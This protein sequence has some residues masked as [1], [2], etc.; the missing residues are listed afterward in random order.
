MHVYFSGCSSL[1]PNRSRYA[2]SKFCPV[3]DRLIRKVRHAGSVSAVSAV[4]RC[5]SS[6]ARVL[7]VLS[8]TLTVLGVPDVQGDTFTWKSNAGNRLDTP[9][10]WTN[11]AFPTGK[12]TAIT[13]DDD[14]ILT[15]STTAANP[16]RL[17]AALSARSL[18][19]NSTNTNSI[20]GRGNPYVLTLGEGG[21]TVNSPVIGRSGLFLGTGFGGQ[22][23][24]INIVM[25]AS[26]TW[27]NA[28]QLRVVDSITNNGHTLT[29]D[30]AGTT[31]LGGAAAAA[32]SGTGGL[33]KDGTGTL[34]LAGTNTFTGD[35]KVNAGTLLLSN[36]LALQNSGLNTD[37]AGSVSVV[38]TTLSLGGLL[39]SGNLAT[40][41]TSGYSG[42]TALTLNLA[43]TN[44]D[45][46]NGIVAN[47]A[48]NMTV[49][50]AGTGTQ[51]F[52]GANT[53]SGATT[54]SAGALRAA[55]N[56]ALGTN[57]AGT[58]V[59]SGAALELDGGIT[60]GA[61]SLGLS[62]TGISSNGALRN[63]S[64]SNTY[65]GA[66]TLN[67]AS[68]INADAGTLTI[69]SPTNITGAF[70]L[71]FGGSG[72]VVVND[73]IAT[74]AG[75][76]GKD[77]T[78]TVT[79]GATNS[80][81]G[82]TTINAGTLAYGTDNAIGT[83]GITISNSAALLNEGVATLDIGSFSDSVGAVTLIN[84]NIVGTT[85]VLTSTVTYVMQSG[86]VSANLAGNV[87]LSK[88]TTGTVVLSGSN[89]YTG[90]TTNSIAGSVLR[91][92]NSSAL[93]VTNGRTIVVSGAALEL[94]GGIEIGAEGL[95]LDGTGVSAGGALR[96]ISGNNIYGGTILINSLTRINS[97]A[98]TLTLDVATGDAITGSNDA[99]QFGGTGDIVIND[100]IA[101]GSGAVTKDG[102]GR[103]TLAGSNSFTSL[104]TISNGAVRVADNFG[105]GAINSGVTVISGA[106]LELSNNVVIGAEALTLNADGI[107]GTGALRNVQ[108]TNT[109]GGVIS[110]ATAA[111]IEADA[112]TQLN[113]T[114]T[115]GGNG[116]KTFD[117]PGNIFATNVISGTGTVTKTGVG[118][119]TL[120]SAANSFTNTL[121]V[122]NGTLSIA[123]INNA[124][125]TGTLGNSANAVTLGGSGTTG[126][127]LYTGNTAAS[128]KAFSLATG[129]AGAV[130]VDDNSAALTLSGAISGEGA[131]A[132][133]GA[134]ALVL[135][136]TNNYGGGT[137]VSAGTLAG[138]SASLQGNIT[139]NA[140]L[141]FDQSAN[142]TYAG[143]ASGSG[144][145]TKTGAGTLT[146]SGNNTY[147]GATT[148]AGGALSVSADNN[149][150]AATGAATAGQITLSNGGTLAVTAGFTLSANRGI[151][152]ETGGG[153]I[154]VA[155]GQNLSYAG[156]MAGS[157]AFNK[158]GAGTLTLSSSNSYTGMNT[159]SAGTVRAENSR[160]LGSL[161]AG[162]AITLAGGNLQLAADT[163][164]IFG[165]NTGYGTII[166]SNTTITSD[167]LTAGAGVTQQLGTLTMGAQTFS[168]ER[169]ANV[170]SGIATLAIGGATTL[171]GNA[172]FATAADT[173]LRF[174]NTLSGAVN[175]TKTGEGILTLNRGGGQ[176]DNTIT[177]GQLNIN[178]F[179]AL[180]TLPGTLTLSGG[181]TL[182]NTATNSVTVGNAKSISLGSTLTFLGSTNLNLGSGVTTL[183]NNTAIDVVANTLTL[184]G[185]VVGGAFGLTKNGAGTL[186]LLG[187]T[188]TNSFTGNSFIN[189]GEL[190]LNGTSRFGGTS[191]TVVTVETNA[192]LRVGASAGLGNVTLVLNNPEGLIL[193]GVITNDVTISNSGTIS[194]NY[195]N[196]DGTITIGEGVTVSSAANNFGTIPSTNTPGRIVMDND[197]TLAATATF[198]IDE[199]QGILLQPGVATFS[200]GTNVQVFIASSITGDGELRKTGAGNIR[201]TGS[202]SYTGGTVIDQGIIGITSD[203][204]LGAVSGQVKLN[205]GTLVAAQNNT[206]G[207]TNS[208]TTVNIDRTIVLGNGTTNNIDAQSSL[209]FEYNGVI[210]E[211]NG[212]GAA[213]SMRFGI[214]GTRE[215][216]VKLGGLNTYDGSSTIVAGTLEISN[217]ADGGQASGIGQSGN[218]ASNL[219]IGGTLRYAGTN[220]STDRLFSLGASGAGTIDSGSGTLAFTNTG[221]VGYAATNLSR[222]D[223]TLTGSGQ[224]TLAL[225]LVN[226][227]H[228]DPLHI[229]KNG[230]GTWTLSGSNDYT[231]TTTI[232]GGTLQISADA[233]LGRVAGSEG[234]VFNNGG[235]LKTTGSLT[236]S[237]LVAMTG[238][239]T[240]DTDGNAVEF[241]GAMSGSGALTK[242]GAGTL[243]LSG[244]STFAGGTV[245]NTGTLRLGS[246]TGAG[247]GAITQSNGSSKL[248]IDTTGTV[249][250]AM[251]IYN[252]TTLQNV[253]L[254]GDKT[255]NNATFDVAA[256]TTYT[257]SGQLSGDGG[258]DK[259]GAG[260][261]VLAGTTNNTYTGATVISNG[262]LVLSNSAGN[263][264]NNSSSITVQSGA[265]LIL[266]AS[267]QI[268]DG[269]GLTLNGGTFIVGNA[270]AGYSETLGTLTLSASSTIDLGSYSTGLR[271]LTFA[272]SSA[273]TWT[274][275]LTITNWQG[276]T[277]SS[278]DVAEILFGTGGL[279]STQL[280]QIYFANQEVSGG[281]LV[282]ENGEL[283]PIPEAEVYWAALAIVLAVVYRERRRVALLWRRLSSGPLAKTGWRAARAS[284]PYHGDSLF[285]VGTAGP[286]R[287][288]AERGD[289]AVHC[290]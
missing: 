185:D 89:S 197:S 1:G 87:G 2:P 226:D 222:H 218:A 113:L 53:Y 59:A 244:A 97:D 56:S 207:P 88:T 153:A 229:V 39:G 106:A 145:L 288:H 85:G 223:L 201:L 140:V 283:V 287:P 125:S 265:S 182:D 63:I 177:A 180:G 33:V 166:S 75:T 220:A 122:Q 138:S 254:T 6:H 174:N 250:N 135:A 157:G 69:D 74:G 3:I 137:L 241:S 152:L 86:S 20:G 49:T 31:T 4:L 58:T 269:I 12:T 13:I 5:A 90:V 148:I 191:N 159:I 204:S 160:S 71:V 72:N 195:A 211:E 200:P 154:N 256:N 284:R 156:N 262:A 290:D 73:T 61:E 109:Y 260:T 263:G 235:T 273:I 119:L 141:V 35:T 149:L 108:G 228:N 112:D 259:I 258:L 25:A 46:Y 164:T 168:V 78:G 282:G 189:A 205:N 79:L 217:I 34:I 193:A 82:L 253:T 96:N 242:N 183:T 147:S 150:G 24:A 176:V 7:L 51:V 170:S 272:N 28:T 99:L 37:G 215:G 107:G 232:A 26:Q 66:I 45:T 40:V 70:G 181:V 38:L 22:T 274:G 186:E 32:I 41:I 249:A 131:F 221:A 80:Y 67:A 187:L 105:L 50:K 281:V 165:A 155:S 264:I 83:N 128:T 278:S 23:G 247:T 43:A 18:T 84:G 142:G 42:L 209:F 208:G 60:I 116:N 44:T 27:S 98:G 126:E 243:T 268:A 194:T 214:A 55:N 64:G 115:I 206:G 198:T 29:I 210:G 139:N 236:N 270:T 188:G 19:V 224:G 132:K 127:L 248:V 95:T 231:G 202:N 279:T 14:L 111:V 289:M 62:G 54:I 245:L 163:A 120:G 133:N 230:N 17:Q 162:D 134:G 199:N 117:G 30:G 179:Q 171:N 286:S 48:A 114:N 167:R 52:A 257:E 36:A 110:F 151:A 92:A 266:G 129:G 234:L 169:G 225:A 146:L 240:V 251:S 172:T 100:R 144:V 261:L 246:A 271:Q 124:N 130:N 237:R 121:T 91:I 15:N 175:I 81:T 280:G 143:A 93:G 275:T 65:G 16:D 21:I 101:T 255:L 216:T 219:V 158:T 192:F 238:A 173:E 277:R 57:S 233:N 239:G 94:E 184:G 267:S 77:G 47:G 68:R 196:I 76:L 252:I 9:G 8:A 123:T 178:H 10:N 136:G 11:A 102:T 203:S 104:L 212:A 190:F 213:S 118:T 103:L 161:N 285:A 276:M 227:V